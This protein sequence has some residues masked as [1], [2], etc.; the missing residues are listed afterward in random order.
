MS[1]FTAAEITQHEN[2]IRQYLEVIAN[3]EGIDAAREF[4]EE[5]LRIPSLDALDHAE[6]EVYREYLARPPPPENQYA[7]PQ[8]D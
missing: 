8:G 4:A 7:S 5:N 6:D 2:G 3:T 1:H